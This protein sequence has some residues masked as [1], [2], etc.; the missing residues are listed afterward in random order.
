M[1]SLGGRWGSPFVWL[2]RMCVWRGP[3]FL[4]APG[5][6]FVGSLVGSLGFLVGS[7]GSLW[8]VLGGPRLFGCTGR[9]FCASQ[10]LPVPT[11]SL[12]GFAQTLHSFAQALH[13]MSNQECRVGDLPVLP[14]VPFLSFAPKTDHQTVHQTVPHTA[15]WGVPWGVPWGCPVGVPRGVP[16]GVRRGSPRGV[17]GGVPRGT[18]RGIPEQW[19]CPILGLRV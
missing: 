19:W 3:A 15:P 1:G 2:H 9:T 4:A 13:K 10:D 5:E 11:K 12:F 6:R 7:L 8:G 16:W 17:P 14:V 18:P